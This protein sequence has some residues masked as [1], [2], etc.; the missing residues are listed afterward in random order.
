MEPRY[1]SGHRPIRNYLLAG[2]APRP[3]SVTMFRPALTAALASVLLLGGCGG[4][5]DND[6]IAVTAISEGRTDLN[7]GRL[8]LSDG[9]GL[10]RAGTAQGL[11]AFDAQGRIYPALAERW[12]A[13]ED[14]LSYIFRI[15]D[16]QWNGGGEVSA[17]QVARI[18]SGRLGELRRGGFREDLA[19]IAEVDAITEHVLEI[20]LTRPRPNLLELLAQPEFGI[21]RGMAGSGP[22]RASRDG[23]DLVL[24]HRSFALED[25]KETLVAPRIRL[26]QRAPA[27][28]IAA[29]AAG[30]TDIVEGGRFQ[31]LPLLTAAGI[32][33]AAVS[34]DPAPGLFG[35][36]QVDN[37]PFLSDPENRAAIAKALDRPA[38]L[39]D[40]DR[41]DWTPSSAIWPADL[42]G[43]EPLAPPV[44]AEGA[45]AERREQAARQVAD[46]S[47]QHD[48]P[49]PL[50]LSLPGGAGGRILFA[51][52]AADLAAIGLEARRVGPTADADFRLI[53][54]VA[55]YDGPLWYL[56][57]L[58]CPEAPVCNELAEA[59]LAAALEAPNLGE[60]RRLLRE[61]ALQL[62]DGVNFIPLASPLRFSL[63]RPGI[64]GHAPN[65]RGWHLLQYLGG[66]PTS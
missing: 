40:F 33:A 34:V 16:A 6:S 17:R 1:S 61:A 19:L 28:A 46:W 29:Y 20:R 18:L 54:R 15:G 12:I 64:A 32:D 5:V 43:P 58:T 65:S 56:A 60:R 24:M 42:F 9:A 57:R 11:V 66:G 62:Q 53:D 8:P 49:A 63:V 59:S 39:A 22:M 4:A 25:G 36:L 51:R 30:V 14:G 38:L 26:R 44:W 50:R 41:P 35:L 21:V 13:S 48:P 7:I 47:A 23:G 45:L 3:H 37:T 2:P 27:N 52:I 10:L 31:H 55:D